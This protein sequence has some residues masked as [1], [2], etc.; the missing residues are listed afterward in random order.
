[1]AS[2]GQLKEVEKYLPRIARYMRLDLPGSDPETSKRYLEDIKAALQLDDTE[3]ALKLAKEAFYH[4]AP[5]PEFILSNALKLRHDGEKLLRSK[6]FK[7]A[8]AKF[9]EAINRYSEAIEIVYIR[10]EED[11]ERA[12]KL[13]NTLETTR[14]LR[15]IANFRMIFKKIKDAK[16]EKELWDALKELEKAEVPMEDDR[17]DAILTAH[18]KIIRLQLQGVV[19]LMTDAA[20]KFKEENWYSAK[21]AFEKAKQILENLLNTAKKYQ[22][23]EEV[24]MIGEL[25]KA[26]NENL[27]GIEELLYSG[28]A[29]KGWKLRIPSKESFKITEETI[30]EEFFDHSINFETRLEQIKEKYVITRLIGEGAFSYVY[31]A[32]NPR[33]Q[34]IA[35]KVLKYLDKEST[36]SFMREFAAA[37]KLNHENIVKVYRAD[38]RLGY[39]E[40]ELASGNIDDVRKPLEPIVAGKVIFEVSRA[41]HHAHSNGIIHRDIKPSNMLF[42]GSI[43]RVKLG[44]WGLARLASRATRKSSLVRHKTILYSS[45]EQIVNPENLDARSDIFQLGIVFYELLTGIHPFSA[46]YEGTIMHKILTENPAPP[47]H[48]N[49]KALPFDDIVMKMLEKDPEK[50]YQTVKELQNDIK[51]VLIRMGVRI[52]ASLGTRERARIIAENVLLRLTTVIEGSVMN[53][54]EEFAEIVRD[55]EELHLETGDPSIKNLMEQLKTMAEMGAKPSEETLKEAKLILKRWV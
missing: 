34:K 36:S 26:C 30:E 10:E 24:G 11:G 25:L 44:D 5:D 12:R 22:L 17:F 49:P 21:K 28:E 4:V 52:K 47:S 29:P 7:D 27:R 19:D 46:D 55:L 53:V 9:D 33:G 16:T 41:L 48:H 1:M 20:S 3:R 31:E 39:L 37:Q 45:P 43:E 35:L 54:T 14:N 13:R 42:F 15:N 32:K 2:L 51:D 8:I 18:K 40:M 23:E 38:P 6:K 50:R